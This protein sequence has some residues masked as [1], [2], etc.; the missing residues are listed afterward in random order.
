MKKKIFTGLATGAMLFSVMTVAQAASIIMEGNYVRT[1]ISDDGTLGYGGGT[2]PGLLHDATGTGTFS[3]DDYL[4][5]GDPFEL[6]SVKSTQTGLLINNNDSSSDS[7]SGSVSD[8][9]ASSSYDHHVT[10]TGT[11]G[12]YL[13]I[14]TET[15]FNDNDERVSFSTVLT[16]LQDLNGLEFLRSIDPDPDVNTYGSFDTVNGRGYDAN[17]DGDFN[18]AGDVAPEDWVHAE[19]TSTGLTLGLYSDSAYTHNTGVTAWSSDPTDFLNG[20]D[21]GNG[22]NTI[23]IAFSI[24]DLMTGESATLDYS[25][26]M[27]AN[28]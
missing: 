4:T 8:T 27:G 13:S 10:W 25:Y 22:D 1:A 24:G 18:D 19:G 3:V 2:S 7:I 5:P 21:I 14:T 15:F 17:G 9:S 26:I 23:G 28:L 20:T 11:Y 12:S 6:F 16:A